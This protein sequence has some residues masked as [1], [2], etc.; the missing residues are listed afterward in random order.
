M[1]RYNCQNEVV[2]LPRIR[3]FII[4]QQTT[5]IPVY[6]KQLMKKYNLQIFLFPVLLLCSLNISYAQSFSEFKNDVKEFY[7]LGPKLGHKII[8]P[9][10][11]DIQIFLISS[12]A[13][14]ASFLLDKSIRELRHKNQTHFNDCLFKIDRYYGHKY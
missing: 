8:Q 1:C 14:A 7:Y 13:V 9:E 4:I 10:K 6:K 11:E 5:S 2:K 12:A 3:D